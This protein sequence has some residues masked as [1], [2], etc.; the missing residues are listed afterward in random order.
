MTTPLADISITNEIEETNRW[1]YDVEVFAD[2]RVYRHKVTLAYSDYDLWCKGRV[3][4]S[5]VVHAAFTFLL[6]REPASAILSKFDCAL[7][8]MYFPEV[9]KTLPTLL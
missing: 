4:P 8:R 6:K 3:A 1:S 9:D 7:I 5:R 2:G